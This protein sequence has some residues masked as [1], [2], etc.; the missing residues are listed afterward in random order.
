MWRT[1]TRHSDANAQTTEVASSN[2]EG[3][4]ASPP[5]LQGESAFRSLGADGHACSVGAGNAWRPV[6][7]LRPTAVA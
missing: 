1:L 4:L 7:V 2:V 6:E 5:P 3:W